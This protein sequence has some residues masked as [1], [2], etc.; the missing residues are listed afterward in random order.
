MSDAGAA[1]RTCLAVLPAVWRSESAGEKRQRLCD[2]LS[3][4]DA[5]SVCKDAV[6]RSAD[7]PSGARAS[8]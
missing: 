1:T 5:L 2:G 8:G 4:K 6:K 3:K 7:A